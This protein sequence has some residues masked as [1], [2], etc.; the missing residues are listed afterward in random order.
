VNTRRKG[1][2]LTH[3]GGELL[4]RGSAGW[5]VDY[6]DKYWRS[7]LSAMKAFEGT[8]ERA[9]MRGIKVGLSIQRLETA[10]FS[11]VH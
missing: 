2:S 9:V 4:E 10:S 1:Y 3:F 11:K 5:I 7:D 6:D 8:M